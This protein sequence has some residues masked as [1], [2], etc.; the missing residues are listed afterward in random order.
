M[1]SISIKFKYKGKDFSFRISPSDSDEWNGRKKDKLI[2]DIHYCEDYNEICVY[3]V[4]KSDNHIQ[5]I[6]SQKIK[7]NKKLLHKVEQFMSIL[8]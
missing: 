6:Y 5:S 3:D 2:F 8:E 7:D 1:K 4:T